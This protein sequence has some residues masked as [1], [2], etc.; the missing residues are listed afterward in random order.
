MTVVVAP[1]PAAET[2]PIHYTLDEGAGSAAGN[3]GYDSTFGDGGFQGA[4][5]WTESGKFG[6]GVDLPGGGSASNSHVVL[7]NNIEQD[8]EDEFSVSIW[9]NPRALP[10]WVPLLQIG[11]STDTSSCCSPPPRRPG[12]RRTSRPDSR[13]PSRPPATPTRSG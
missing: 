6:P 13:P 1:P 2:P 11:S 9:A 12:R 8:L 10:N 7:P 4:T 3:T 5:G